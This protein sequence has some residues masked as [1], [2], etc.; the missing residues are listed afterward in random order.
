MFKKM[1][2]WNRKQK[3]HQSSPEL[4]QQFEIFGVMKEDDTHHIPMRVFS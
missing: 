3:H 4:K 2:F 1:H